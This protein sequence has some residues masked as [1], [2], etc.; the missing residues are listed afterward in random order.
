MALKTETTEGVGLHF[1][2]SDEP[3]PDELFQGDLLVRTPELESLLAR[4]YPWIHQNRNT[5]QYFVVLTQSC[6]LVLRGTPNARADH[7]TLAA[8][9]PLDLLLRRD[10]FRLQSS[11]ERK[12]EICFSERKEG[13]IRRM[14]RLISNEEPPYFYFHPSA[15][16]PFQEAHV[17]F[18]RI[19]FALRTEDHYGKCLEA[20]KLQLAEPF[21]AKLGWLTTHVFGRVATEDFPESERSRMASEYVGSIQGLRWYRRSTLQHAAHRGRGTGALD[22]LTAEELD[23]LLRGVEKETH[24]GLVAQRVLEIVRE[25][26]TANDDDLLALQQE[27]ARDLQ[28]RRLIEG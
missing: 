3:N 22:Q 1:A 4:L 23:D 9:R 19:S 17:A 5:Y 18:L 24:V 11:L 28:L 15:E 13:F 26:L 20:K 8:V 27:L 7:I 21:R 14:E 10:V 25:V 6:D 2:Y 12:H 16:T